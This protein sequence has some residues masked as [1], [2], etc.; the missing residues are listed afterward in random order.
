MNQGLGWTLEGQNRVSSHYSPAH[1][2]SSPL[3]AE[4]LA[5]REAISK[6]RDQGLAKIRVESNSAVLIKAIQT[7]SS[8]AGLCG[9]L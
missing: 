3:V 8:L 5:I 6:C 9:I 2:V 7:S 1:H 4:G